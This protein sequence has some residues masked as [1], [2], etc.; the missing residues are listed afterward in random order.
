VPDNSDRGRLPPG[1][2]PPQKPV[3]RPPKEDIVHSWNLDAFWEDFPWEDVSFFNREVYIEWPDTPLFGP[4]DAFQVP[5]GQVL[6]FSSVLFRVIMA[7][8]PDPGPPGPPYFLAPDD[9]ILF[10]SSFRWLISGRNPI[11]RYLLVQGATGFETSEYDLLNR[12]IATP[13][14]PWRIYAKEGEE[15]RTEFRRGLDLYPNA[16]YAGVEYQGIWIPITLWYKYRKEF[17]G[18]DR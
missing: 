5:K 2:R 17:T 10:N 12:N 15:V 4:V 6:C 18:G 9:L 11:D 16:S 13:G 14:L 1:F 7:Q 3:G 8:S